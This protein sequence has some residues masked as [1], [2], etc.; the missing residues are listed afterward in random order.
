MTVC[1][2]LTDFVV[3]VQPQVGDC[4]TDSR[5]KSK[6]GVCTLPVFRVSWSGNLH[7]VEKS[8]RVAC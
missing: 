2:E 7:V 8:S 4:T 1:Q 6:F 5:D 3:H